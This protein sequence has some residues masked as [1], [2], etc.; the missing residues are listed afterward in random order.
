M[1]LVDN[2]LNFLSRCPCQNHVCYGF[3]FLFAPAFFL[4]GLS[5]MVCRRS[6]SVMASCLRSKGSKAKCNFFLSQLVEF[7]RPFLAS[8]AWIILGMFRGDCYV[9]IRG[10]PRKLCVSDEKKINDVD[11]DQ[12]YGQS[13]IIASACLV[14][15]AIFST[16]IV[17]IQRYCTNND[18]HLPTHDDLVRLK[19]KAIVKAFDEKTKQ[20]ANEFAEKIVEDSFCVRDSELTVD[21][22]FILARE[23]VMDIYEDKRIDEYIVDCPVSHLRAMDFTSTSTM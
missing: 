22:R 2:L 16:G 18:R 1:F 7:F 19:N 21:Q 10:G 14:A 17:C 11:F 9:C 3:A 5:T 15:M 12:L 13:F 23:K 8:V 4:L 6:W 20:V